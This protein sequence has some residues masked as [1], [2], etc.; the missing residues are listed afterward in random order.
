V[1]VRWR[2]ISDVAR[3]SRQGGIHVEIFLDVD[4]DGI[5]IGRGNRQ[6]GSIKG[7]AL[8]GIGGQRRAA[9]GCV[10][11]Q[12]R[13]KK[14]RIETTCLHGWS[15]FRGNLERAGR[16]FL[17]LI[18]VIEEH[19]VLQDRPAY[20]PA[21][22]VVTLPRLRAAGRGVEV[23]SRIQGVVLEIVIEGAVKLTARALGD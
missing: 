7:A 4:S 10:K 12:S 18:V 14:R 19:F 16:V 15:W 11:L 8:G 20:R 3:Q 13:S 6:I 5:E 17:L 9:M 21:E 2:Q 1:I 23:A 22:V